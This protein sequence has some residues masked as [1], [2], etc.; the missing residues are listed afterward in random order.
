MEQAISLALSLP[1]HPIRADILWTLF[2][3]VCEQ[4]AVSDVRRV[5]RPCCSIIDTGMS[6]SVPSCDPLSGT[7]S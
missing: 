5:P 7:S 4:E 2:E 1:Y 3:N 6:S